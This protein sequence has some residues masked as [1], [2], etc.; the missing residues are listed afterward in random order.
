MLLSIFIHVNVFGCDLFIFTNIWTPYHIDSAM[1]ILIYLLIEALKTQLNYTPESGAPGVGFMLP[2][3][4]LT[5]PH[6]GQLLVFQIFSYWILFII[7]RP[8]YLI[9][10]NPLL[11]ICLADLSTQPDACLLTSFK[12]SFIRC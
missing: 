1:N 10:T 9:N 3:S 8:L 6:I 7:L 2:Q 5:A 11:V 12:N 4:V